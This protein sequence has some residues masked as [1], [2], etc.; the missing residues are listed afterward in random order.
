ML[1]R[2][3]LSHSQKLSPSP[4]APS[5]RPSV[6]PVPPPPSRPPANR[7]PRRKDVPASGGNAQGSG[8]RSGGILV[9]LNSH[10]Q[11]QHQD[12]QRYDENGWATGTTS[13]TTTT[14]AQTA[15]Q[16][17]PPSLSITASPSLLH[18]VNPVTERAAL[19]S[20]EASRVHRDTQCQRDLPSDSRSRSPVRHLRSDH[21]AITPPSK[22]LLEFTP[23]THERSATSST[24]TPLVRGTIEYRSISDQNILKLKHLNS[25]VFPVVYNENFYRDVLQL[26]PQHL[27]S[28]AYVDS[29][30]VGAICCRK[31][32]LYPQ[33]DPR[34]TPGLS[35]V[36]IMTLGVLSPYRRLRLGS[37][38]LTRIIEAVEEEGTAVEL[39]LHVQTTNAQ[40][41]AFYERHGFVK[42]GLCKD[43]YSKNKGVLPPDAWA[44]RR[45]CE[46]RPA[47]AI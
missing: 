37:A 36:Y 15:S 27:S 2:P 29:Q 5:D 25:I 42:V 17:P 34:S 38:L 1:A 12:Q 35:R 19:R 16:I 28:M 20:V 24:P 23:I 3:F 18:L 10:K 31:E 41:L 9:W 30:P 43:Y 44:L 7:R 45:V 39:A 47:A 21:A 14:L 13:V 32:P 4:D 46:R 26:H 22:P 40:A 6:T 8:Q 11:Q 33:T